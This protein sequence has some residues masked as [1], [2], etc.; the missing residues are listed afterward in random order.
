MVVVAGGGL[1]LVNGSVSKWQSAGGPKQ[2]IPIRN[3]YRLPNSW[4]FTVEIPPPDEVP[5]NVVTIPESAM[6]I[7]EYS[8]SITKT[9]LFKASCTKTHALSSR[10]L[11]VPFQLPPWLNC[12]AFP[13]GPLSMNESPNS[14]A[15][16]G[17]TAPDVAPP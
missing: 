2:T 17:L 5:P 11:R 4:S 16:M 13:K 1:H 9:G 8:M 7:D 6:K 15:V 3:A 14:V 10:V 12:A